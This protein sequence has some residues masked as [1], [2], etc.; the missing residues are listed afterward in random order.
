[1]DA[2]AAVETSALRTRRAPIEIRIAT[3]DEDV[4]EAQE[5]R[6]RVG[7]ACGYVA[8]DP[9]GLDADGYDEGAFVFVARVSGGDEAG[10]LVGTVRL[11]GRVDGL[12]S[13][14]RCGFDLP[15]WLPRD[16]SLEVSRWVAVPAGGPF[17]AIAL[18]TAAERVCRRDGITHPISTSTEN[19]VRSI[20]RGG[21]EPIFLGD[22]RRPLAEHGCDDLFHPVVL[23]VRAEP[24]PLPEHIAIVGI[25]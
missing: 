11:A 7:R 13:M 17:V 18:A 4:R 6:Y 5:L 10:R 3:S 1:M 25:P 21:W 19:A 23:P 24:L 16:R 20:R 8:D 14:E 2:S 9:T 12:F 15:D 22:P